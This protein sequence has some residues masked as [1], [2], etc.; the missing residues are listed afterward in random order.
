M[1]FFKIH[2]IPQNSFKLIRKIYHR[3][4]SR[5]QNLN[6]TKEIVRVIR[7]ANY[8]ASL[9]DFYREKATS[10]LAYLHACAQSQSQN[11]EG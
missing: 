4:R 8:V 7:N 1:P 5:I 3:P 9:A 10:R 6:G 11:T 2:F